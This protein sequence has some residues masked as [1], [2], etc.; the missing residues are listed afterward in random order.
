MPLATSNFL[1]PNG[2]FIVVLLAFFVVLYVIGKKVLPVLNKAL[3]ER[4]DQIRGELE[5]ADKAK[6][7]A[8]DADT[9]RRAALEQARTQAREIVAQATATADQTVVSA[10]ARGQATYERIVQAADAEVAVARQAAVEEVTARVGEIVLAA[11]ERV[12]GRE[13]QAGDHQDLINEAIAAVRAESGTG[14]A[15]GAAGSSR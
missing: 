12:I 11:A 2:T 14:A 13:I 15:A 5:A 3:T 6:A 4:Q 1:V 9:E 7:D 10:E 8:E